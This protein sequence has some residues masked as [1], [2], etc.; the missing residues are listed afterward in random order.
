MDNISL[1]TPRKQC[2]FFECQLVFTCQ[3]ANSS[4]EAC[5]KNHHSSL[6][7]HK[8]SR[9]LH[10]RPCFI[11]GWLLARIAD[12]VGTETLLLKCMSKVSLMLDSG[13]LTQKLLHSMAG[14]VLSE[15]H[16]FV[17]IE[18]ALNFTMDLDLIMDLQI[19][20]TLIFLFC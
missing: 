7:F 17:L 20:M 16:T 1:R 5:F 19:Y 11:S 4:R 12:D 10:P 3:N 15:D 8:K 2:F 14:T 18:F 13:F 9:L 6:T